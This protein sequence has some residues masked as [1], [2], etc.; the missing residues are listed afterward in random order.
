MALTPPAANEKAQV[1]SGDFNGDR[2]ADLLLAI[3]HGASSASFTTFM[4]SGGA[5][6]IYQVAR[7]AFQGEMPGVSL[8]D[9]NGDGLGDVLLS[10][11]H[12][13]HS[14]ATC[15]F[16]AT[17]DHASLYWVLSRDGAVTFP[18]AATAC[19]TETTFWA[20]P[21]T[22]DINPFAAQV[23][24]DHR[25]DVF[26]F[27]AGS[28]NGVLRYELNDRSGP[29]MGDEVFSRWRQADVDGD[30][31]SDWIYTT[32]GNPGLIVSELRA[33]PDGTFAFASQTMASTAG[34]FASVNSVAH[35]L[36]ADVGSPSGRPDGRADIV[37]IDDAR[38]RIVTLL[39]QSGGAW[40]AVPASYTA[41]STVLK[42]HVVTHRGDKFNW[43][44]MDVN[45]DGL[46][47]LVHTSLEQPATGRGTLQVETLLARGD[48]TWQGPVHARHLIAAFDDANVQDFMPSD[49]NGDGRMDL[50]LVSTYAGQTFGATANLA[51]RTLM[52]AGGGTW[53]ETGMQLVTQPFQS[54][55]RWIPMEV[56]GDGRTDLVHVS[57][58]PGGQPT[59]TYL[60]SLGNGGWSDV[61]SAVLDPNPGVIDTQA[62]LDVQLADLDH[63]GQQEIVLGGNMPSGG[64]GLATGVLIVWNRYPAFLPRWTTGLDFPS[65]NTA[66]WSLTD[67]GADDQLEFVRLRRV[68]PPLME[69]ISLPAPGV[70]LTRLTNGMGGSEEIVYG[71]SAGSHRMLPVGAL[72]RVVR[73]L[74]IRASDNAAP[75]A[76]RTYTYAGATYLHGRR[77]QF[78]GFERVEFAD[79]LQIAGSDFDLD[80]RCGAMARQSDLMAPD[81]RLIRRTVRTF[82][83]PSTA[84]LAPSYC[85]ERTVRVEEW[86]LE[87]TP[88]TSVA[89]TTYDL[90][91]NV[92][93]IRED[94]DP[95]TLSDDR[96][97]ETAVNPLVDADHFI[98]DR[99]MWRRVVGFDAAGNPRTLAETR[100]EYDNSG[101]YLNQPGAT[102]D[103]TRE[104]RFDEPLNRWSATR[105]EHDPRG[106]IVKFTGPGIPSNPG[107]VTVTI[108]HDCE[109]ARFPTRIC[110]AS[111]CSYMEWDRAMG[112]LRE[113]RDPNGAVTTVVLDALGRP[114]VVRYPD[115]SFERWRWP[116][117]ADWN[118]LRQ[119]LTRELSD[120]S[121]S[122]GV[123]WIASRLDGLGRTI[124]VTREGDAQEEIAFEGASNRVMSRSAPH[125]SKEP[126][127][128]TRYSYDPAGR[129]RLVQHPDGSARRVRFAVGGKTVTDEVGAS[130]AYDFDNGFGRIAAV[131]ENRRDCVAETC[132]VVESAVTRY[133]YDALDRLLR[134]L[135]H[136][137]NETTL[138]WGAFGPYG[139]AIR[140]AAACTR[141]GISTNPGI[142]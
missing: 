79:T 41:S 64:T 104:E 18:T 94:G 86:E 92:E 67:L 81:R 45:G 11:R 26:Q 76:V 56:N 23:N 127:Q 88:R 128:T 139:S 119:V 59:L 98:L 17:F 9:M 4:T 8:G 132:P 133:S 62:V 87:S 55:R 78:A 84:T 138:A 42:G 63:D 82:D 113:I 71:T 24:G 13:P 46:T 3:E 16:D 54:A 126:A 91:G 110:D 93:T 116:A 34:D 73:M 51:I 134:V 85:R 77:R 83:G 14:S 69:T 109:F 38:Q 2:R 35:W 49:V 25:A 130:T 90:W 74:S 65:A 70:R 22:S 68:V 136:D 141:R 125:R 1:L 57:S 43:R 140:I 47:D 75:V 97:L 142:G 19:Y 58:I 112:A 36:L 137:K 12:S 53:R 124:E 107:G 114:D 100:Y 66:S 135:D 27:V 21:W 52:A 32:Y 129:L 33:L 10:F 40:V 5:S 111:S 101:N 115:K 50:V 118:T 37:V 89:T 15:N 96:L 20:G 121:P 122:G 117:P 106:N 6:A 30:G 102:G 72:A 80:D 95:A 123:T 99:P 28:F 39:A 131:R 48:G 31:R 108:D 29:F 105:F 60:L 120:D 44:Q 7:Q 61:N 103:V